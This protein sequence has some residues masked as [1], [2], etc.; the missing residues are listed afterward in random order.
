MLGRTFSFWRRLVGKA[1][2]ETG[3][4]RRLWVRYPA[5]VRTSV[6]PGSG[7]PSAEQ[8]RENRVSAMVRDVSAGGA[9]LIVS[10]AFQPGQMLSL[11]LPQQSADKADRHLARAEP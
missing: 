4:E 3:E 9:N 5:D 6:L 7:L 8:S 2:A 1:P 11:E 10:Q